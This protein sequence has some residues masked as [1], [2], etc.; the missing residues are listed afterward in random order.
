M[1]ADAKARQAADAAIAA[2]RPHIPADA[3]CY[4]CRDDASR[5]GLVSGCGCHSGAGIAHVSCL[6]RQ[7][8]IS[9]ADYEETG[10]N[11]GIEKWERCFLCG[12]M[13]RPGA[14]IVVL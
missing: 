11:E 14:G 13:Y 5:E 1:Y 9:V 10:T 2:C 8:R 4:I 12:Q 7:A 6:V 3:I